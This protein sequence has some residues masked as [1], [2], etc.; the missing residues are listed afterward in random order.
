DIL[1]MQFHRRGEEEFRALAAEMAA[2][3]EEAFPPVR[4]NRYLMSGGYNL[5]KILT[6]TLHLHNPYIRFS[7]SSLAAIGSAAAAAGGTAR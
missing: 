2:F 3:L 7:F 5:S 4:E 1:A 6:H